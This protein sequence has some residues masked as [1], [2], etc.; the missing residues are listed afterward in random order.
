VGRCR[1]QTREGWATRLFD[2][3]ARGVTFCRTPYNLKDAQD[4]I[5][6]ANLPRQT[7]PAQ[8]EHYR[9]AD[10]L[11]NAAMDEGMRR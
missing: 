7:P 1:Q 10:E 6:A 2:C 3:E 11:A 4:R 8:R 5:V 9:E